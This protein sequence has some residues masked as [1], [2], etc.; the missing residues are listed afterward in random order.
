MSVLALLVAACG[1][2]DDEIADVGASS[3]A[4]EFDDE[5]A[6]VG[7][8]SEA[9]ELVDAREAIGEV[10]RTYVATDALA[11]IEVSDAALR[12]VSDGF[13]DSFSDERLRELVP[14]F[15]DGVR[16]DG[17]PLDVLTDAEA[18]VVVENTKD[19]VN[20]GD[21][22]TEMMEGLEAAGNPPEIVECMLVA[23]STDDFARGVLRFS[24]FDVEM[25]GPAA[26][27]LFDDDCLVDAMAQLLITEL[28]ASSVSE[29]AAM[30]LVD[31]VDLLAVFADTISQEEFMDIMNACQAN[32]G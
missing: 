2:D 4:E 13:L 31:Q 6:D 3:E 26:L 5:T 30:C 17:I 7:A 25:S 24:L 10:L 22:S 27:L 23:I 1:G 19:C 16:F 12:C 11:D 29:A 28:V 20:W 9:E 21:L 8:S 15:A 32:E 18:E 14:V